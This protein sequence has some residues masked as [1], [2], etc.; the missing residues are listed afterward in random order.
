MNTTLTLASS[1]V[2]KHLREGFRGRKVQV[3]AQ[4]TFTIPADAGL[5]SGGSRETFELV[6]LAD[7]ASA[8]HKLQ[9]ASPWAPQRADHEV[10]IPEGFALRIRWRFC[11]KTEDLT[12]VVNPANLTGLLPAGEQVP[13]ILERGA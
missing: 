5:S 4:A 11:G 8:E 13:A 12:L 3:R 2:P 10:T 1:Q 7:G 9:Q 6:R